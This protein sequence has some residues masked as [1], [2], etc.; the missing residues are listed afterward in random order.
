M[1]NKTS[2][3]SKS[4]NLL[5]IA[6]V[7]VAGFGVFTYYQGQVEKS[8]KKETSILL[9]FS[10]SDV[11]FVENELKTL[12]TR[13][14][15][16]VSGYDRNKYFSTWKTAVNYGFSDIP[17]SCNTRE[18]VL[19][20][21]GQNVKYN[22]KCSISSGTWVSPYTNEKITGKANIDIDHLVPLGDAWKSGANVWSSQKRF[23]Y[24]NSPDVLIISDSHSNREK[25]DKSPDEWMPAKNQCGYVVKWVSVKYEYKLSVTS[26]EKNFIEK[27][28][29]ECDAK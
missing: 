26:N 25:S 10:P 24:A 28:L 8:N 1:N 18:A 16:D 11:P 21:Q 17:S 22:N 7:I 13:N 2:I 23:E 12:K 6:L 5:S 3:P 29:N 14:N 27:E 19:I 9:P 15:K 4:V 20:L